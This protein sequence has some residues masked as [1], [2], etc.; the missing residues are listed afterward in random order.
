MNN[1]VNTGE[2]NTQLNIL[3]TSILN[4]MGKFKRKSFITN[5]YVNPHDIQLSNN[6]THKKLNSFKNY[7]NNKNNKNKKYSKKSTKL[8][9]NKLQTNQQTNQQTNRYQNH[10]HQ[11]YIQQLISQYY[12]NDKITKQF[13]QFAT[14]KTHIFPCKSRIIVIGDIHGDFEIA[15]K[16]LE[17]SKCIEPISQMP[18]TKSIT[19]M[20]HFFNGLKWIGGDTHIIQLGDQ[21]DRIR[22]QSWDINNIS[23][24]KSITS[25][26]DEGSTLELFYL[27]NHLDKLAKPYKGRVLCIIGNHE[28]MNTEGDF[29]YV[30][31]QEFNSFNTHLKSIYHQDSKYP[32]ES[33][34]LLKHKTLLYNNTAYKP[35]GYRERL[36]AFA[37]TGLCANLIANN[38]YTIL[39][40]GSWLFCHGSPT[41]NTLSTYNVE[42]LNSI[43]SMYLLGMD[44]TANDI[45][46]N[47]ENIIHPVNKKDKGVL[48][49]RE[50]GEHLKGTHKTKKIDQDIDEILKQYNIKNN[51]ITQAKYISIGHT[52]QFSHNMGINSICNGK[53]W[54]CDVG[55]SKAFGTDITGER[56]PQ[57]LEILNDNQIN[58]LS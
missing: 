18:N 46:N 58:I 41:L 57:V 3:I 29:R 40:V 10:K 16:C 11:T 27:F 14:V 6:N 36:Y 37:P 19:E 54:R 23:N 42:L 26:D 30:S 50:F 12:D 7:K 4:N 8:Q 53:V 9:Q 38:Y 20:T 52:P 25:F 44:S 1:K 43:V 33:K 13:L 39:Q 2:N 32:Y 17:I 21:I 49:S 47:Y 28:I 56:R 34:T 51:P 15:L 35:N 5:S 24:D 55:M 22:P 31:K 48:W 45:S